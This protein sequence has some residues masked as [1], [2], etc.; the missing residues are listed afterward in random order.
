MN[1]DKE[2]S[3]FLLSQK[4]GIDCFK[5]NNGFAVLINHSIGGFCNNDDRPV[6]EIHTYLK[7]NNS[8]YELYEHFF[9]PFSDSEI[10][11]YLKQ[12]YTDEITNR[13]NNNDTTDA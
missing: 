5:F 10:N 7:N 13:G 8:V 2:V 9:D 4:D 11:N 1:Y 12:V 6:R 3:Q